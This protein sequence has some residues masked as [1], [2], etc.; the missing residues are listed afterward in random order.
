MK[1]I[2]PFLWF[3]T[4][5]E[6]AMNFYASVFKNS[7]VGDV[8][9]GPDGKAFTVNFQLE[10][11]DFIALNAGPLFKFN[12]SISMFVSCE[13]QAEVDYFWNKLTAEGGEESQ[14]GWL[15]DKYGLS[16]QIVPKQLGDYI[17][18]PDPVK[19][20]RGMQAMLKMKKIIVADLQKAY[21]GE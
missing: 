10:G 1:K 2:T 12:E 17:G 8:S 15:K 14:C 7:K 21:H 5:A 11:Q 19:A 3:D 16:W 6:E 18:G 13:D 20:Q 4:Q 9:R